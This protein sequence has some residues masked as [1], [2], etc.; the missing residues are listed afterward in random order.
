M[1]L[2]QTILLLIFLSFV[3]GLSA[4]RNLAAISFVPDKSVAVLR[5][6]WTQ[7]RI[8]EKLKPIVNGDNFAQTV[9]QIGVSEAKIS[10][11]IVFSDINPTSSNGLGMIV[12]GNFTLQSVV[13]FAKSKDWKAEKIGANMAFV[14]PSD[15]SY[16]LPLRNGLLVAGTK[17]G[18][19][20]V[21]I[22][23][24][25]SRRSLLEKQ[26]FTS[27]W[28]QIDGNRQPIS[29]FIGIPQDYQQIADIAFKVVTKLMDLTSFGLIG[30]VFET[31]GLVRSLGF[32]VSYNKDVFPT[33][34]VAMM[35]SETKAWVASGALN[36]LRKAPSAIGLQAKTKEDEKMLKSLQT[37]SASY[38]GALLSVKFEMP[39]NAMLKP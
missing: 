38:K 22:I 26:P 20:K 9:G 10:E 1:K 16:L 23:I 5:V 11:W 21:Q 14:N 28:T 15:N 2:A 24:A 7:V 6:K 37:M 29:L 3:S 33:K 18:V 25:D 34:L 32:T 17:T 31:I 13:Q 30:K 12:S 4:Q 35:D 39:E 36:L 8:N 19:E 27:V